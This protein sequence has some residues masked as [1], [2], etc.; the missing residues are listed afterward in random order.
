LRAARKTVNESSG[1]WGA[2]SRHACAGRVVVA[3][4]GFEAGLSSVR[5]QPTRRGQCLA[6]H[7]RP[8][9]AGRFALDVK[10]ISLACHEPGHKGRRLAPL[11]PPRH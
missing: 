4:H 10:R 7:R 1:Q 6:L 11:P 8:G 5:L 3:L 2:F 9:D